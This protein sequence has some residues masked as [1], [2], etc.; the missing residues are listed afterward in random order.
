M[1]CYV[2]KRQY[3]GVAS[4]KKEAKQIAAQAM[5]K[6]I[7]QADDEDDHDNRSSTSS[8]CCSVKSLGATAL[9]SSTESVC[10]S[11]SIDMTCIAK[12]IAICQE[13]CLKLPEYVFF[14]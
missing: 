3:F 6:S 10:E 9:Q 2:G 1:G 8:D 13:N 5:L 14:F 12:L 7:Q 4:T 11:Q